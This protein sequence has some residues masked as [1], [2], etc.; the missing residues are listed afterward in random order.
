MKQESINVNAS[1]LLI[2]TKIG[3]RLKDLRAPV[4]EAAQITLTQSQ[5]ALAAI[6]VYEWLRNGVKAGFQA[7]SVQNTEV[8]SSAEIAKIAGVSTASIEKAKQVEKQ[9]TPEIKAAVAKGEM[10]IGT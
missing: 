6:K 9:A 5:I 7:S 8:K 3:L 4:I 2:N 1:K 10:S